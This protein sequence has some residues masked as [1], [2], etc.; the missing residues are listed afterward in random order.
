MEVHIH[1]LP[2]EPCVAIKKVD[3]VL[4]IAAMVVNVSTAISDAEYQI[5]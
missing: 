1:I 3:D 5:I 2:W 4:V